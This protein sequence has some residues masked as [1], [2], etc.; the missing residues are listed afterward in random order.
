MSRSAARTIWTTAGR[1]LEG[2]HKHDCPKGGH[3]L[4][5]LAKFPGDRQD[6]FQLRFEDYWRQGEWYAYVEPIRA[7]LRAAGWKNVPDVP[8]NRVRTQKKAARRP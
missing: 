4:Q 6:E 2:E 7:C 1:Q 8:P 3:R 5:F